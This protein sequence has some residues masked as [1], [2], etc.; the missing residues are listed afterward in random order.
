MKTY[1]IT[2]ISGFLGRNIVNEILKEKDN[3]II[4]L[5]F[6]NEKNLDVLKQISNISL[7]EGNILDE[8]SIDGFL[9]IPSK[10]EKIIIHAA[11]KISVYKKGDPLTTK[12]NYEGTKIVVDSALR[13]GCDKFVYVSSVDSLNKSKGDTPIYEQDY[14][15]IDKVD[16]VYSKS[17]VLA[18]NYVLDAVI[19]RGLKATIVLPSV[20][21]GPSD[22]F[23]SPINLAF[24]KF[25]NG[26][27][28]ILVKGKYNISDVRDVAKGILL[29]SKKGNIGESYLL[30]G[31]QLPILDLINKVA[32]YD[33][34]KPIK[35]TVPVFLV[36]LVAPFIEL[37]AKLHKKNPLFTGFSMD[38][39]RQNSNYQNDKAVK[40][41]GFAIT[42]IDQ[43][44]A[45]T[46]D[47]M[48]SSGYLKK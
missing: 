42:N 45:D 15:E 11:G 5:V 44:I 26:K 23:N 25:L 30:T 40:E 22:P 37:H 14:Y 18:N 10:G 16:G 20:M 6:P 4:G 43:T 46:V 48:K 35:M 9:S 12:I 33:N 36:K 7:V 17:K 24:K 1:Y 47:W 34:R 13:N 29:A 28:G 41:L 39:L 19:N 38:C 8:K 32:K 3:Y 31:V 2:G 27:L 21:I